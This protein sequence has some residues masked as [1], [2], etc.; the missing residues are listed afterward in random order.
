MCVIRVSTPTFVGVV[1]A[2][3]KEEIVLPVVVV[4]VIV[5]F[6]GVIVDFKRFG[7]SCV[8]IVPRWATCVAPLLGSLCPLYVIRFS[9]GTV[10]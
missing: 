1:V 7:N 2:V 3:I 4:A 9:S 5:I 8:V 6:I 10:L